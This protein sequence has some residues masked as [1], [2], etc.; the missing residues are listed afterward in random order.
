MMAVDESSEGDPAGEVLESPENED[1]R[2]PSSDAGSDGNV[3]TIDCESVPVESGFPIQAKHQRVMNTG[4][5][6]W[7]PIHQQAMNRFNFIT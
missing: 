7:W 4:P 2:I 5:I 6:L 3:V 1:E